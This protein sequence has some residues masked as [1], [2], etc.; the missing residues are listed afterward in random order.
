M[1]NA[2]PII[3]YARCITAS[4]KIDGVVHR[5]P[6][7]LLLASCVALSRKL[8]NLP[9][10]H[11]LVEKG[12][13]GAGLAD[14]HWTS[15]YRHLRTTDSVCALVRAAFRRHSGPVALAQLTLLALP[16]RNHT[17]EYFAARTPRGAYYCVFRRICS[18][19]RHASVFHAPYTCRLVRLY[20]GYRIAFSVGDMAPVAVP[21]LI[22]DTDTACP[23][24]LH[25]WDL[26]SA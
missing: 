21:A 14:K 25:F 12:R 1:P 3:A 9:R 19:C 23:T 24:S 15:L 17:R 5:T 26:V 13:V 10:R 6:R 11:V 16:V 22:F 2:R 7:E 8:S 18:R 4:S 20:R